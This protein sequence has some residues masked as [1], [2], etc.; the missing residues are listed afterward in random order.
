MEMILGNTCIVLLEWGLDKIMTVTVDNASANDSGVSY[1]RRQM[2]SLKTSIA[3]GKYLH[4]RCAAHIINL[5]V[6]DGLK[7]V[8]QS[9]KRVRAAVKFIRGG[10][11]RLEKF[12]EIAQWEKVDSKAFL[13]LDVCT[14]WNSTYDMLKAAC[15]QDWLRRA[16]PINIEE[17]TEELA[18][19]EE[20]IIQEFKD[21]AIVDAH[22]APS[23]IQG[24][25]KKMVTSTNISS[26]PSKSS[27]LSKSS[28]NK[29][30]S[31]DK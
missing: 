30:L 19:L 22:A 25:K 11:S 24:S 2:N 29:S 15:T 8:D 23:Q 27:Q 3:E 18:K 7:E 10:T 13:N 4:M 26:Q 5:I 31:K 21:K 20:E 6:Q 28:K 14:R 17:N 12:K 9:I 16:T 1:L